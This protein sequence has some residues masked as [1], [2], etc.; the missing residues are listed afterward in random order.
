MTQPPIPI[1]SLAEGNRVPLAMRNALARALS[2]SPDQ[3]F[4]TVAAFIDAFEGK[5]PVDT[6]PMPA[7]R[8]PQKT[9][10][11][12][13]LDVA[14][15]F[16]PGADA[17]REPH[18]PGYTPAAG[19]MTF[20]TGAS[21]ARVGVPPPPPPSIPG[22]ANRTPLLVAAGLIGVASVVAIAFALRGAHRGGRDVVF[23]TG[24]AT[25]PATTIAPVA[26]ADSATAPE[27]KPSDIPPLA[28]G[29]PPKRSPA[30]GAPAG[31]AHSG[32]AAPGASTAPSARPEPSSFPGIP[33]GIVLPSGL[34][35]FPQVPQPTATQSPS[36]TSQPTSQVPPQPA[37]PFPPQIPQTTPQGK[38]DGI[39]CQR[40]RQFRALGRAREA[41]SW[42]DAC[43]RR[44]GTP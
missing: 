27:T 19:N 24:S 7:G 28:G 44:G 22:H 42:A 30:A 18:P 16:G 33:S 13:P 2:K 11:G 34:P 23:D 31:G 17:A 3:R 20:P 6:S 8:V 15:A 38:Y 35:P 9:E 4:Q 12:A 43:I 41:Q 39:E 36:P 1:E 29:Q 10:L 26:P 40:A 32:P 21:P 25:A 5:A 37:P 14:A